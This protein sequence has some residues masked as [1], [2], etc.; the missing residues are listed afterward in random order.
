MVVY[1]NKP[2][3]YELT[4]GELFLVDDLITGGKITVNPGLEVPLQF[5]NS[6]KWQLDEA[7][8]TTAAKVPEYGPAHLIIRQRI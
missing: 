1:N 5:D 2:D 6:R 8:E 7:H 4:I 3:I